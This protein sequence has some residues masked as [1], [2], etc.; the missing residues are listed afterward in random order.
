MPVT[1]PAYGRKPQPSVTAPDK[2]SQKAA[3]KAARDK[4]ARDA[5]LAVIL[6]TTMVG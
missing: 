4:A 1:R 3:A 2:R 6:T 5:A